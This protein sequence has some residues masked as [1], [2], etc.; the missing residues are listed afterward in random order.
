MRDSYR[1]RFRHVLVD[2]YQDTNHAQYRLIRQLTAPDDEVET[3]PAELTVVGDSDQS[4]YAFR[5]ADIRNITEFERD[6]PQARVIK[7][8]QNYRSTQNILD[9]ANA[10]ISPEHRPSGEEPLDG[11]RRWAGRDPPRGTLGVGRGSVDRSDHR[12]SRRR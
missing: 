2:E 3:S 4:I 11:V 9:A 6:Y 7:L 5:G 12:P 10:V 1:R 8:E